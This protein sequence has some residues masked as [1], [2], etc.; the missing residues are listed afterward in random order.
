MRKR[1]D[2]PFCIRRIGL[3]DVKA[4]RLSTRHFYINLLRWY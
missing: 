3:E 2:S 4:L 1:S